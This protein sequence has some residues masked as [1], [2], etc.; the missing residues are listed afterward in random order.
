M[1]TGS[2]LGVLEAWMMMAATMG[3]DEAPE[4]HHHRSTIAILVKLIRQ[5]HQNARSKSLAPT[6]QHADTPVRQR[7]GACSILNTYLPITEL[8]YRAFGKQTY[9]TV[10]HCR[11]L[12]PFDFTLVAT[13]QTSNRCKAHVL[14]I[15]KLCGSVV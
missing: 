11:L 13:G 8:S 2:L 14:A 3:D 6:G 1:Q 5:S 10:R 4:H 12:L 15:I 7:G 9:S